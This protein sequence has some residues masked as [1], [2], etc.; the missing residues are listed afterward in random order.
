MT[1][2]K[3]K[4]LIERAKN[5]DPAAF[6]ELVLQ[7]ERRL[8]SFAYS[9]TGGD[10]ESASEILQEALLNAF[11]YVKNFKGDSTFFTW[12]WRIVKNEFMK[13]NIKKRSI[14]TIPFDDISEINITKRKLIENDE[15]DSEK[16]KNIRKL[17]GMLPVKYKEVITLIDLQELS[18]D[19]VAGILGIS[20]SAMRS[21][22]FRAR[23]ELAKLARENKDLFL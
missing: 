1:E 17:I 21:R 15:I 16:R 19:E 4:K 12:L 11:Q 2:E 18:Y 20:K 14:T 5:G 22:L 6:E 9:L 8:S 10:R 13:Y 23:E 3:Q 7:Y